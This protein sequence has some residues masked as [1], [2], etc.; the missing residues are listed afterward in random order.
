MGRFPQCFSAYIGV[1]CWKDRLR[2]SGD[3]RTVH[4]AGIGGAFT[5]KGKIPF[6]LGTWH[7]P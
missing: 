1:I 7:P 4:L 6:I 5:K 3:L 2:G